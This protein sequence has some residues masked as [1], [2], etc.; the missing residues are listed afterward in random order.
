M[1]VNEIVCMYVCVWGGGVN[2][3]NLT[4]LFE[5]GKVF[6]AVILFTNADL[7][8]DGDPLIN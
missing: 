8:F 3:L 6:I 5:E 4:H 7:L 2:Y 1:I